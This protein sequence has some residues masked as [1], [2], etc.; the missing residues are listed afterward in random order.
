MRLSYNSLGHATIVGD[1][2]SS[3]VLPAPTPEALPVGG[4]KN[5]EGIHSV[6]SAENY[7][8][9]TTTNP[10]KP[11]IDSDAPAAPNVRR[12]EIW[13]DD[14]GVLYELQYG[15]PPSAKTLAAV[16]A[17]LPAGFHGKR[18]VLKRLQP[19]KM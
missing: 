3:D 15:P 9:H 12:A 4:F 6:L 8:I 19:A 11:P 16:I 1:D 13:L 7:Y 5:G 18:V 17:L 10:S 14:D 2:R